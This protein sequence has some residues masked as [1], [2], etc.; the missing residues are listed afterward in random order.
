MSRSSITCAL[1][2]AGSSSSSIWPRSK[3][4]RTSSGTPGGSFGRG[5]TSSFKRARFCRAAAWASAP[6]RCTLSAV[7]AVG[8]TSGSGTKWASS[9][10]ISSAEASR[11][12]ARSLFMRMAASR[13]AR[14]M[15]RSTSCRT[16][17]RNARRPAASRSWKRGTCVRSFF[18]RDIASWARHD[19]FRSAAT[20]S[21]LKTREKCVIPLSRKWARK[22]FLP[23]ASSPPL[24]G[25]LITSMKRQNSSSAMLSL[26]V[27]LT[28][29]FRSRKCARRGA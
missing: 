15:G 21:S 24:P 19:S 1:S 13:S 4:S 29:S 7:R 3:S 17:R 23:A 20:R 5:R 14:A 28:R 11:V 8:S 26:S 25:S 9:S 27:R 18:R 12:E 2:P 10:S 6:G 22:R 16:C